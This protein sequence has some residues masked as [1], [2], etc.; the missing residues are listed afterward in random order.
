MKAQLL[1][2]VKDA[3]NVL[4]W[5]TPKSSEIHRMVKIWGD[6]KQSNNGFPFGMCEWLG[7]QVTD[8]GLAQSHYQAESCTLT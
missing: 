6:I 5:S 2:S 8:E 1:F 4:N 7:H 3:Y